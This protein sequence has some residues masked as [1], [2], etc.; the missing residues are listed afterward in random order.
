MVAVTSLVAADDRGP[1]DAVRLGGWW[2]LGHSVTLM[3]VGLPIILFKS[4][5]P[6]GL[7]SAAEKA[8]GIVILVLAARVIWKWMRGG[9][10]VERHRHPERGHRHVHTHE[11]HG[12]RQV[13]S[14]RQALAIGVLHGLAGSGAVALLLIA[15][16]PT[17]L[18][19]AAALAVFA[20]MS[21]LSMAL[22][23]GAFAWILT[24]PLVEPIYRTVLIPG[25]GAFGLMFGLWYAG[26]A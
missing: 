21:A 25:F 9:Y 3:L 15:A 12:H 7:E 23:S 8:V 2:G 5:L 1:R 22:C 24:R 16:L 18:E 13:R 10:R 26:L 19:A 4:A 14:P 6:T 17:Q 20:P 11:H